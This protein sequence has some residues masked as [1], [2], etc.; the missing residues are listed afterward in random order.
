[1][2]S[3]HLFLDAN[4]LLDLIIPWRRKSFLCSDILM[5]EIKKGNFRGWTVDYVMSEIL[6]ELK[7]E[8][9]KKI[10]VSNISKQTLSPY[11][12]KKLEL[13]VINLRNIPNFDIFK[14]DPPITQEKIFKTLKELCI[15]AKDALVILSAVALQRKVGNVTFITRDQ[16]LLVRGK[17][18][19][20]TAN[21]SFFMA[22]CPQ[23]C[24]SYKNCKYRKP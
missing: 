22:S 9:E 10:G 20:N 17:K 19:I 3:K 13:I 5:N 2:S 24:L 11:E 7:A 6:G 1:M 8:R 18:L 16:K 4:I 12:V 15:Q 14:P 21:P 23:S